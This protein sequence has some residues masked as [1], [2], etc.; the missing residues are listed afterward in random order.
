MAIINRLGT[1]P[2]LTLYT[3]LHN[4]KTMPV[5]GNN[6]PSVTPPTL[7]INSAL[8]YI[9]FR[10]LVILTIIQGLIEINV[11]QCVEIYR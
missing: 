1:V 3:E 5:R 2:V 6:K 7:Y 4:D 8:V 11:T 10:N 9:P